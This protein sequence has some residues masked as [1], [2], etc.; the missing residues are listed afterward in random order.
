[1]KNRQ[2]RNNKPPP[3]KDELEVLSSS[4]LSSLEVIESGTAMIQS[5]PVLDSA[6][7]TASE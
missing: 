7:I 5:P 3:S 1:M 4:S 2:R 6:A